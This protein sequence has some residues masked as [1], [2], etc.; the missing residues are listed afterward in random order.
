MLSNHVSQFL[1]II[2]NGITFIRLDDPF[3]FHVCCR[4][5]FSLFSFVICGVFFFY[6]ESNC[7][8]FC[9]LLNDNEKEQIGTNDLERVA[10]TIERDL[11]EGL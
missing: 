7:H 8:S 5:L 11:T 2:I 6:A 9:F 10:V 1:S 3:S 4:P